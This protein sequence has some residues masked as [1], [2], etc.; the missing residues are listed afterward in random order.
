MSLSSPKAVSDTIQVIPEVLEEA[1]FYLG[2]APDEVTHPLEVPV[3]LPAVKGR[4]FGCL[5]HRQ[6]HL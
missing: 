4:C 2:V 3:S 5:M 6:L 1:G